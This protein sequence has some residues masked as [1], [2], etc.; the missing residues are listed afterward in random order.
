MTKVIGIVAESA[1][2]AALCYQTICREA[3]RSM[4]DYG[5]KMHEASVRFAPTYAYRV[6]SQPIISTP[7][8]FIEAEARAQ[9]ADVDVYLSNFRPLKHTLSGRD[10]KT[11]MKLVVDAE[12]GDVLGAH[13][14]GSEVTEL[15]GELGLAKLLESTTKE[16]GWLVHPH[17]TIS[18]MVKEAA[19]AAEDE[20]IHI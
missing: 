10:E 2:G 5:I 18:E 20:A 13:M 17:P 8:E 15:L 4:G 19:L 14:I 1:E 6:L 9:L 16:L 3:P 11:V 12:I 7:E